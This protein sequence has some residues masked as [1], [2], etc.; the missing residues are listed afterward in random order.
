[1]SRKIAVSKVEQLLVDLGIPAQR[2]VPYDW[3]TNRSPLGDE[4]PAPPRVRYRLMAIHTRLGGDWSRL[5]QKRSMPIRFDFQV[6]AE[7]LIE[8]DSRYHFSS[9]RMTTLDFYED[10]DHSLDVD[11]YR[12]LCSRFSTAADRYRSQRAASDFPFPGGRTAQRAYFD[13]AKDLLAPAYGYRL[14]RLPAADDDLMES[15]GL[16][17][18]VLL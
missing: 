2:N 13:A 6:D 11:L 3:V 17:L 16:R 10:L 1:M 14:I 8:V 18:R 4:F 15:I 12:E 9:A 7:T 5:E